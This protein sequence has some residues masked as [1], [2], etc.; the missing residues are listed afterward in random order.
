MEEVVC[1]SKKIKLRSLEMLD[2]RHFWQNKCHIPMGRI[3]KVPV[4][5]SKAASSFGV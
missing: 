4:R 2:G 5:D 3:Y 1:G